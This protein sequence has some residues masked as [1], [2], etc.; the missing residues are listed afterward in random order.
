MD[1]ETDP[2]EDFYQF[3]CGRWADEHPRPD[4]V[5][6]NDWFRERQARIMRQLREFL[7][8]NISESEPEAVTKAK[9]MYRACM[10]VETLEVREMEPLVHFLNEFKLPLIPSGL[11][12]TLSPENAKKYETKEKFNWLESMVMIKK[13]LS[14]DLIIG[15]DIF[16]DPFNRTINR[17]ALGTPETDSALP[18]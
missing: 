13:H 1:E 14:M 15:F 6:S 5:T 9:L 10:D 7:K 11:N 8:Q 17:I 16:P 18:L 4:T 12:I 2:C 3:A